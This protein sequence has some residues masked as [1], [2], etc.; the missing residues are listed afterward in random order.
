M[1]VPFGRTDGPADMTK[2]LFAFLNVANAPKSEGKLQYC[3][4]LKAG[5]KTFKNMAVLSR[6]ECGLAIQRPPHTQHCT[7]V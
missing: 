3:S 2:L 1:F 5:A 4:V 7:V 6:Q